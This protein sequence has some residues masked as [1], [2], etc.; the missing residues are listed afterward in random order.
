MRSLFYNLNDG[1]L[2][3]G[4]ISQ[5]DTLPSCFIYPGRL[6]SFNNIL[7]INTVS[8]TSVPH[9]S[10]VSSEPIHSGLLARQLAAQIVHLQ[11][12]AASDIEH[13]V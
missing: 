12:D 13:N 9:F 7:Y 8:I 10:T 2:C 4:L 1:G 5:A 6:T 11:S 3:F